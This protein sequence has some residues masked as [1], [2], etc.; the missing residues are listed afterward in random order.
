MVRSPETRRCCR[1]PPETQRKPIP[2]KRC[3][4]GIFASVRI[5]A[6]GASAVPDAQASFR[7]AAPCTAGMDIGSGAGMCEAEQNVGRQT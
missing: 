1:C 2:M 7:H 3:K 5:A 4:L 6:A